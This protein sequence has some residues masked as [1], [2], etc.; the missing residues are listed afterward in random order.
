VKT[1][2]V[3]KST[4]RTC[5]LFTVQFMV[6]SIILLVELIVDCVAGVSVAAG[7]MGSVATVCI[8]LH[9]AAATTWED[10]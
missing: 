2:I 3:T 6:H 1:V 8:L 7:Y 10:T 4:G 5:W 9:R